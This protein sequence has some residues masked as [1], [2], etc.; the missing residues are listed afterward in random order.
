M[1]NLVITAIVKAKSEYRKDVLDLLL[2]MVEKTRLEEACLQYDLHQDL[3]D[4]STFVFY[5]VWSDQAGLDQHNQQPYIQLFGSII[6]T[7]L[8]ESPQLFITQKM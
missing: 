3:S 1:K 7:H 4:A 2:D 6:N 8:R 5:E